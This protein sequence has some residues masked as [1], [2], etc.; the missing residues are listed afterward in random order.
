MIGRRI[1]L[2]T[3]TIKKFE[4]SIAMV[5]IFLAVGS[6]FAMKSIS[7]RCVRLK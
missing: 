1:Q 2:E 4:I 7:E 3:E 5:S 6:A